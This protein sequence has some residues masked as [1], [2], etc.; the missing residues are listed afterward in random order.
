MPDALPTAPSGIDHAGIVHNL[1]LPLVVFAG[2]RVIYRNKAADRLTR[3]LREHYSTE[4]VT[5]LRDH[6]SQI[7]AT[8]TQGDTLTLVRLPEGSRLF[9]DVSSLDGGQRVVTVHAPGMDLSVI[10][11]HYRLS[12]KELTVVG[13]VIRG[14]SNQTIADLMKVS[15]DTVKKHLTSVF[16][17]LGVDSRTQLMS[18]VS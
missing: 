15:T 16:D 4:L 9:I 3:W 12:P 5:V 8:G 14:H 2:A 13:H 17:K 11:Q 6:V 1:R 18:L 10:A 7:R